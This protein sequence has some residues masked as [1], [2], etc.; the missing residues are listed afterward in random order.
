MMPARFRLPEIPDIGTQKTT[1]ELRPVLFRLSL[2]RFGALHASGIAQRGLTLQTSVARKNRIF[3]SARNEIERGMVSG[4]E[5]RSRAA[6][7][8]EPLSP[9]RP[10]FSRTYSC[11][12]RH[13]QATCSNAYFADRKTIN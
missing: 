12:K 6:W 3:A 13:E 10:F 4:E 5:A 9:R 8:L 1:T 2:R 11:E 7:F